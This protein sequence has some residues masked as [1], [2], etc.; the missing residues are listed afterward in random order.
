VSQRDE[1]V[2]LLIGEPVLEKFTRAMGDGAEIIREL[3]MPLM[4]IYI[5][6]H[7]FKSL[8]NK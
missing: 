3:E 4:R 8:F 6:F 7:L 2:E 1:K 5:L